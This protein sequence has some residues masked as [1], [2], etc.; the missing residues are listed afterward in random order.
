MRLCSLF[1][2]ICLLACSCV[3]SFVNPFACKRSQPNAIQSAKNIFGD[4]EVCGIIHA[5][6]HWQAL[7]RQ[8]DEVIMMSETQSLAGLKILEID[9]ARVRVKFKNK[10][11]IVTFK[12]E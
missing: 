1:I 11:F 7:M 6:G 4:V 9:C 8:G 10:E 5:A 2:S 12:D 3:F